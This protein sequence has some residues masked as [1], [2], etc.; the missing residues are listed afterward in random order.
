MLSN[1]LPVIVRCRFVFIWTQRWTPTHYGKLRW[2]KKITV[3][4]KRT[5][6]DNIAWHTENEI[7]FKFLRNSIPCKK[8]WCICWHLIQQDHPINYGLVL[9]HL[10]DWDCRLTRGPQ[11]LGIYQNGNSRNPFRGCNWLRD[12]RMVFF[13]YADILFNFVISLGVTLP[14]SLPDMYLTLI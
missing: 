5:E 11:F 12:F 14:E 13:N 1:Q 2:W 3:L 9:L 4:D 10:L 6:E 8:V 7:I